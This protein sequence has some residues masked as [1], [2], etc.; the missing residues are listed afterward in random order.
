[1]SGTKAF[2]QVVVAL[3]PGLLFGGALL[4][5]RSD[6][7]GNR[8]RLLA[9]A[10]VIFLALA[11]AAEVV[12]ISGV[13]DPNVGHLAQRFVVFVVVTGTVAVAVWTALPWIKAAAASAWLVGGAV[14]V[15]V[16][17]SIF[18]QVLITSSLDR[19]AARAAWNESGKNSTRQHRQLDEAER[20]RSRARVSAL[21]L[22]TSAQ[23]ARVQPSTRRAVR[24][25]MTRLLARLD[26]PM[27]D[28]RDIELGRITPT[29]AS[30]NG[31]AT[32]NRIFGQA[33]HDLRDLRLRG[34]AGEWADLSLFDLQR[35]YGAWISARINA[36][37][38]R[39]RY[40]EACRAA[41][42]VGCVPPETS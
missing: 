7:S 16:G 36:A 31:A 35:A 12:A 34:A 20:T 2:F 39:R 18:A 33:Q 41:T 23:L 1:V 4:E 6:R 17:A 15:L 25:L 38:A 32:I 10:I 14:V 26:G 13:I 11:V 37:E 8:N 22:S 29:E 5:L 21:N 40:A 28:D 19:S 9:A 30:K 24:A 3:I 27:F 42:N